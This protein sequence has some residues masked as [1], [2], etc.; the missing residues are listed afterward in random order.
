MSVTLKSEDMEATLD[1]AFVL[2]SGKEP[3]PKK[4]LDRAGQLNNSPSVAFVAAVGAVLFARATDPRIDP[5]VIQEQ[6]G[7]AGA[8]SLRG[9][10][11]VLG[12]KHIAYGFDIGSSSVRD[13]VNHGTLIGSTRWDHALAR[14]KPAHK[15]FFQ[16]ILQWLGDVNR[17]SQHEALEALAAYIRIRQTVTPGASLAQISSTLAEAPPLADLVRRPRGVCLC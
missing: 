9:P 6:E 5:F 12:M 15:P 8:F 10:A 13:P 17:L 14:I 16:V 4:W 7:S 11:K 1:N 2:A 3:L